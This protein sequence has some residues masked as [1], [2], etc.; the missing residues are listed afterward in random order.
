MKTA[1]ILHHVVPLLLILL[2]SL[3]LAACKSPP[4]VVQTPATP[5]VAEP[6]APPLPPEPP[7]PSEQELLLAAI[8]EQLRSDEL[9]AP[10]AAA[11][12][13]L[14]TDA[15]SGAELARYRE[16]QIEL[17][18]LRGELP[19]A[20][21]ITRESLALLQGEEADLWPLQQ[22]HWRLLRDAGA[23]LAGARYAA[24]LVPGVADPQRRSLLIEQ[25]WR[26]LQA[27]PMV[28]IE[29]ELARTQPGEW[30]GWLDLVRIH[31]R[32]PSAPE[33]Q[34]AAWQDWQNRY[35]QH[36]ATRIV[37]ASGGQQLAPVPAKVALLLPLSGPLANAG[38]AILDGFLGAWFQ[39]HAQ[40]WPD[41]TIDVLDSN[42]FNDFDAAHRAAAD[43]GAEL[44]I[45]P[46]TRDKL[47]RWRG[48][49][50]VPVLALNWFDADVQ[51]GS[52]VYQM[53]LA[54]EDEASQL[55][56]LAYGEG[57]RRALVVH[58]ADAFGSSVYRSFAESWRRQRGKIAARAVYSGRDD[59][60]TSLHRALGLTE[61]ERRAGLIGQWLGGS[62]EFSPR[63]RRDIDSVILL[64]GNAGEARALKP[65]LAF[66][67]AGDLPVYATSHLFSG[68][69]DPRRD[70]DLNGV[71][72]LDIPWLLDPDDELRRQVAQ[73]GDYQP[74]LAAMYALGADAFLMHWRLSPLRHNPGHPVRGYSGL[75]GMDAEGRVHRQ[76]RPARMVGGEPVASP[77]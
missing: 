54:P 58:S 34:L 16:L 12:A 5:V 41:Q 9:L 64:V 51:A 52:E 17:H 61:S 35:P 36:P 77:D 65:L 72:M 37:A 68:R 4:P 2:L 8:A 6:V 62:V 47:N 15:L 13:Q 1:A 14:D 44:I 18:Y 33:H 19:R 49:T 63:R 11:L 53:A 43:A 60:S 27:V 30:R 32:Q 50:V 55:A 76:L 59:Y 38:A 57:V 40:D 74:S 66:H 21:Q 29:R 20:R 23:S 25:L 10:A 31:P 73:G 39:A 22:W 42:E 56:H 45:G 28:E 70:R 26:E 46:L 7:P 48:T 69:P 71:R 24:G 67:Y 3:L 75:L